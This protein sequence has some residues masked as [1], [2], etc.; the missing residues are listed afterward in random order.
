[1]DGR[2]LCVPRFEASNTATMRLHLVDF[3]FPRE[4]SAQAP[5]TLANDDDDGDEAI[6][7]F[8]IVD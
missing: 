3:H 4:Q 2:F 8:V 1:M 6:G 7:N 5:A